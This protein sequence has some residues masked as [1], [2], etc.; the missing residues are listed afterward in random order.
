MIRCSNVY[1]PKIIFVYLRTHKRAYYIFGYPASGM[2]ISGRSSRIANTV[3]IGC[4]ID[5]IQVEI[6]YLQ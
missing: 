4:L 2:A 3:G 6:N 5:R 1:F